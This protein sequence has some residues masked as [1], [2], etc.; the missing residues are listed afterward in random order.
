M[1]SH[2]IAFPG[3]KK[4]HDDH[5]RYDKRLLYP[6]V[7]EEG[8]KRKN[9]WNG[10]TSVEVH[11]ADNNVCYLQWNDGQNKP[12]EKWMIFIPNTIANPNTMMI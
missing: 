7:V 1:A 10:I 6:R 9:G 8:H 2:K 5:G 12:Y 3:N 4:E 11:P